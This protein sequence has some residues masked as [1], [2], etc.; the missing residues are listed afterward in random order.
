LK[1]IAEDP[2]ADR[3][4]RRVKAELGSRH[5]RDEDPRGDRPTPPR[6]D[7]QQQHSE[8]A[9][10]FGHMPQG[11][12]GDRSAQRHPGQQQQE[13]RRDQ[14]EIAALHRDRTRSACMGRSLDV[15]AW[16]LELRHSGFCAAYQFASAKPRPTR[17]AT[18]A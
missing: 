17:C 13:S 9:Q 1:D 16:G 3:E 7:A 11:L 15:V 10:A 8:P 2:Q 18:Q 12:S 4:G 5:H 6:E 14:L